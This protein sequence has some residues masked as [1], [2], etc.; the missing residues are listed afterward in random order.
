VVACECDECSACSGS[1]RRN[2][3][4][5]RG[6]GDYREG[7]RKRKEVLHIRGKFESAAEAEES[8]GGEAGSQGRIQHIQVLQ[9]Q[10]KVTL[11]STPPLKACT[12]QFHQRPSIGRIHICGSHSQTRVTFIK[13]LLRHQTCL[14]IVEAAYNQ[15]Q[16]HQF[17]DRARRTA[18]RNSAVQER[19]RGEVASEAALN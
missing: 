7:L 10:A 4:V 18:A 5:E 12:C 11:P 13:E 9:Q 14:T 1:E 15:V 6:V 2:A 3:E 17:G 8:V 19:C 16:K